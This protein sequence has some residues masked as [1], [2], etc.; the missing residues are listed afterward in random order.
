MAPRR[1]IVHPGFHK[2]GTTTVQTYL[3]ENGKHIWPRSA[4]VLPGRTRGGAARM[5]VRYSR[6]G[7]ADLLTGFRDEL[8][9][10][11]SALDVGTSRK[12][13]ISDEN[14][15]G[16]M[17]G[18]DGQQGYGA[19]PALMAAA[20][21]VIHMVFGNDAEVNFHLSTRGPESWLRSTFRHNL[22]HSRVVL[23]FDD[24]RALFGAASDLKSVA[25][26]IAGAVK[27]RV[28]IRDIDGL[29]G[30]EG[31]AAPL[32]D[33]LNLPRHL[34]GRLTLK[35]HMNAGPPEALV[36][37]LLAINR[38][39]ISDRAAQ[40]AKANLLEEDKTP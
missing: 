33:L 20:E 28:Q 10:T 11:L 5:A 6:F 27:G 12:V 26:D 32:I 21:D 40:T 30:P 3:R 8:H 2:T 29:D 7:T 31:L 34:R 25:Q 15:L 37:E 22:F 16:R 14:L 19:A 9:R 38:S 13:L 18:R 1:I 36:D 4:L 35:D 39:A 24:Y 17:P 23:D